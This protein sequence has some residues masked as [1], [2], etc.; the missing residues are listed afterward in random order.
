MG[1]LPLAV[2]LVLGRRTLGEF[3]SGRVG[4]DGLHEGLEDGQGHRAVVDVLDGRVRAGVADPDRDGELGGVAAEP[5]V[6]GVGGS[7]GGSRLAGDGLLD[8]GVAGNAGAAT[9][10]DGFEDLGHGRG[11]A[12]GEGLG[13]LVLVRVHDLAGARLDLGDGNGCAVLSA[14]GE[15]SVSV[16]HLQRRDV[17]GAQ[18][19]REDVVHRGG[20]QTEALA[21]LQDVLIADGLGQLHVAGVGRHGGRGGKGAVPVVVITNVLDLD[22][23]ATGIV[24]VHGG[25]AVDGD[26]GIHTHLDGGG[27]GEALE[28]G[29]GLAFGGRM[30]DVVGVGVV[31]AAAD[32]GL[33]VT[34][35]GVDNAH[36]DLQVVCGRV[37]VD[38]L[39]GSG[40]GGLL[41]RGVDGGGHGEATLEQDVGGELLL[42]QRLHVVDE[43]GMRVHGDAGVGGLGDVECERLGYGGVV[44]ILGDGPDAQHVA[45]NLVAAVDGHIGVDGG[46]VVRG[47]VGQA[48]EQRGLGERELAGILGE[49]RLGGGLDAVS[50]MSVVDGIEV[51]HEDLILG[52]DLLH[53][54]GD[55]SLAHLALDGLVKLLFGQDSVAHELLGDGRGAFGSAGELCQDGASDADDVDAVMLVETLV[56]DVDGALEDPLG[57][58]VGRDALTILDEERGD[59]GALGVQDMRGLAH[60]V[61]V[62][63]RVIGE[64]GEPTVDVAEHADAERDAGDE[65]KAQHGEEHDGGGVRFCA[66]ARMTL[67]RTH[68]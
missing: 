52:E 56:L 50:A 41:D 61:L 17:A 39:D 36:A 4:Q 44:L 30:V 65:E 7:T 53:L 37:L 62:G 1:E 47:R 27:Q 66:R 55:E 59:F 16:G 60:E 67:A 3:L 64:I 9:L 8:P 34:G 46:V 14:V 57:D 54:H 45:E 49:V 12:G 15:G 63:I 43:V 11:I 40:L 10:H 26:V 68:S 24:P 18:R 6:R 22:V 23:L 48:D 2:G 29:S 31:I 38:V 25:L 33:D 5:Q 42:Q 28:G 35:L 51:H 13:L 32:H 58:L 21:G 20:V 19:H